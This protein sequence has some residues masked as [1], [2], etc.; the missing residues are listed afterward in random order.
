MNC[1]VDQAWMQQQLDTGRLVLPRGRF[2]IDRPLR[3]PVNKSGVQIH[4]VGIASTE[5]PRFA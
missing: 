3:T 1:I 4:G 2:V 5:D